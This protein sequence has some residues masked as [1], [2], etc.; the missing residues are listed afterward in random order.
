M[1]TLVVCNTKYAF[2]R[3]YCEKSCADI[4]IAH[5]I[6]AALTAFGV[7]QQGLLLSTLEDYFC[8]Q[9]RIPPGLWYLILE[10][11]RKYGLEQKSEV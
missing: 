7:R 2:P 10:L 3:L 5:I 9:N 6:S 1:W 11:E 8:S 4:G